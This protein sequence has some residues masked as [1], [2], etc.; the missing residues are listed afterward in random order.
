[1]GASSTIHVMERQMERTFSDAELAD[2]RRR[3]GGATVA[4]DAVPLRR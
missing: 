1:M 2:I 3:R 4:R